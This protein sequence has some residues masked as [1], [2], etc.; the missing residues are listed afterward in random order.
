MMIE[1]DIKPLEADIRQE[2]L[3]AEEASTNLIEENKAIEIKQA[4]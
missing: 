2:R 4:K 3:N 1:H